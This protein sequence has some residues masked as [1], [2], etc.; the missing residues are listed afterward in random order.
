MKRE[1]E[2]KEGSSR[3]GCNLARG[4]IVLEGETLYASTGIE[5][6]EGRGD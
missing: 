5:H 3:D 4:Q 2:G 1:G 6:E